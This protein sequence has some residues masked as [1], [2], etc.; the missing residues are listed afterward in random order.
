[1]DTVRDLLETCRRDADADVALL[2]GA[3]GL[4]I[5]QAG[6]ERGG[7][8]TDLPLAAA[9]AT[10]LLRVAD[11]ILRDAVAAGTAHEAW[12]AA[13]ATSVHL[14]RLDEGAFV[15][16]VSGG[17]ADPARA[18]GAVAQVADRLRAVLA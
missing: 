3:D 17:P 7:A 11:R 5:E 13:G 2:V 8:D 10:D 12:C 4:V 16:S 15:L 14:A 18:R 9:E 1:M 6:P